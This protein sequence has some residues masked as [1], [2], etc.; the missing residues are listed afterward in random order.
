MAVVQV[1]YGVQPVESSTPRSGYSFYCSGSP[2]VGDLAFDNG[3][4][5][6]IVAL[7][8][9]YSGQ[10]RSVRLASREET[11]IYRE[12]TQQKSKRCSECGK[13]RLKSFMER[14]GVCWCPKCY[15]AQS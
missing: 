6:T 10:M 3:Q 11:V 12:P 2:T 9:S 1:Q 8:S 13:E 5:V 14:G 15:A 7:G 4:V